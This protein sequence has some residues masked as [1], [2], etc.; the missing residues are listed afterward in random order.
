MYPS[1]S[2]EEIALLGTRSDKDIAWQLNRSVQDVHDKR[3]LLK[4][5]PF[6]APVIG[7][8]TLDNIALLGTDRDATI[9]ARLGIHHVTVAKKRRAMKIPRYRAPN[10]PMQRTR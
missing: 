4:I 1:W 10:K 3:L 6:R 9:A 5:S 2:N 7:I 8:W